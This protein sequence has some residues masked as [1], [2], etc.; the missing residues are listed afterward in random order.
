MKNPALSEIAQFLSE[1]ASH[2]PSPS[3]QLITPTEILE[4]ALEL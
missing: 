1:N 3:K 4:S 2:A